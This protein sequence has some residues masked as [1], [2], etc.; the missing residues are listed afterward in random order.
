MTTDATRDSKMID[1][2]ERNLNS[3]LGSR[4]EMVKRDRLAFMQDWNE[5]R[6]KNEEYII[7]QSAEKEDKPQVKDDTTSNLNNNNAIPNN[8][9]EGKISQEFED[10]QKIERDLTINNLSNLGNKKKPKTERVHNDSESDVSRNEGIDMEVLWTMKRELIAKIDTVDT[11]LNNLNVYTERIFG[12]MTE[13]IIK[14]ESSGGKNN[15][16]VQS[17]GLLGSRIEDVNQFI[18]RI[19]QNNNDINTTNN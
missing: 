3:K 13:E 2:T 11:K 12:G 16:D 6:K 5:M 9:I 14:I 7:K 8:I 1:Q 17:Y 15:N 4:N 10:T 19:M 18:N